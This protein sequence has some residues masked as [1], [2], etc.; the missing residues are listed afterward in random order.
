MRQIVLCY[1]LK[2]TAKG[3][4]LTMIFGYLGYRVRHVEQEEYAC[5]VGAI[6]GSMEMPE[7]L[8]LYQGEG[9]TDEML[10]IHASSEDMLD[11]ALFLMR[12]EKVQVALKAML[13][14]SNQSWDSQTLHDEILKEHL[15]MTQKGTQKD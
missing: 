3:R 12:K 4:K 9:F 10:V 2:G 15:Q 1:N 6:A 14:P 7:E 8:P 5:P 13:T 11:K